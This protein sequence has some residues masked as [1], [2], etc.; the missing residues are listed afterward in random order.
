M[1]D[2]WDQQQEERRGE[3]LYS[4]KGQ[5]SVLWIISTSGPISPCVEWKREARVSLQVRVRAGGT[6]GTEEHG[7]GI[8]PGSHPHSQY[9]IYIFANSDRYAN[10]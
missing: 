10:T 2:T 8:K 6:G 1:H 4:L 3:S 9:S 5:V 7:H